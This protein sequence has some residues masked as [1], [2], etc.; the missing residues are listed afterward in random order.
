MSRAIKIIF[1]T[2]ATLLGIYL[3]RKYSASK[4]LEYYPAGIKTTG[5]KISDFKIIF[6][7]EVV[8]PSYTPLTI[9]NIFL[10]IYD[11]GTQL[12][13]INV[14]TPQEIPANSSTILSLPITMNY[15][16]IIYF[17]YEVIAKGK[18]SVKIAGTINSEG[19][20]VPLNI[21][22]PIN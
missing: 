9:N 21:D 4:K 13:R 11:K 22:I 2:G 19:I 8:N 14:T 1:G 17:L 5:K 15:G 3:L 16:A 10:N 20:A 7:M 18:K 6:E 12:G